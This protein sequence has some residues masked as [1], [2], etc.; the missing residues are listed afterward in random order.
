MQS[1]LLTLRCRPD[2]P[3]PDMQ[4]TCSIAHTIL[5]CYGGRDMSRQAMCRFLLQAVQHRHLSGEMQMLMEITV[6]ETMAAGMTFAAADVVLRQTSPP[7]C[8][9]HRRTVI[10]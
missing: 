1:A 4:L 5:Q 6:W 10:K 2:A 3:Q 9:T 8:G 7:L